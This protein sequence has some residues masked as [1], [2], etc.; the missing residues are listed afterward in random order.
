[1]TFI[2]SF[3]GNRSENVLLAM[4]EEAVDGFVAVAC[5]AM[6]SFDHQHFRSQTSAWRPWP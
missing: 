2:S 4:D 1:M 6:R 3:R 5:G